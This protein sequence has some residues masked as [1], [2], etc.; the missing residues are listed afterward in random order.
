[1]REVSK[2]DSDPLPSLRESE[3]NALIPGQHLSR[4][5][6]SS[7][8]KYNKATIQQKGKLCSLC[9]ATSV[10]GWEGGG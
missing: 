7:S 6:G 8:S 2:K 9:V 3:V 4:L 1:M 10:R 5:L